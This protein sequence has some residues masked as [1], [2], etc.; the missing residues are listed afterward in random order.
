MKAYSF[1]AY[2]KKEDGVYCVPCRLF[3]TKGDRGTA[4]SLL[5]TTPY[6]NWKKFHERMKAHVGGR[7]SP[8]AHCVVSK[9]IP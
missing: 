9:L 3:P 1:L 6:N 2:S 5:V 8:H 7:N 4:P